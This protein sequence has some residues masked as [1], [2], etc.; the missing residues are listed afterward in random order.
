MSVAAAIEIRAGATL[1]T[2]QQGTGQAG[3]V[4]QKSLLPMAATSESFRSGWQSLLASMG[5]TEKNCLGTQDATDRRT[6]SASTEFSE[7]AVKTSVT[8]LAQAASASS[9]MGQ[10]SGKGSAASSVAATFSTI[11][12]PSEASA[13]RQSSIS[14]QP[15]TTKA[16][17][18]KTATNSKGEPARSAGSTTSASSQNSASIG[19]QEAITTG[20]MPEV[21][22]TAIAS[23]PV[24]APQPA[25]NRAAAVAANAGEQSAQTE[26]QNGLATGSSPAFLGQLPAKLESPGEADETRNAAAPS[27]AKNFETPVEEEQS[28]PASGA[29]GLIATTLRET[30]SSST[31]QSTTPSA[32]ISSGSGALPAAPELVQIPSQTATLNQGIEDAQAAGQSALPTAAWNETPVPALS[33][34]HFVPS[35]SQ[36]Q[37]SA[38]GQSMAQGIAASASNGNLISAADTFQIAQ[39]AAAASSANQ[40]DLASAGKASGAARMARVTASRDAV[41][42]A[43]R[44]TEG[45]TANTAADAPVAMHAVASGTASSSSFRSS[46]NAEGESVSSQAFAALDAEN[47]AEKPAW[48]HTGTRSAEAGFQDPELGWV[49]VRADVSGGGVHA[50]VVTGSADAAQAL[51]GHL[52]G[53]N[54]YLTENNTPVATLTMSSSDSNEAAFNSGQSAGQDSGQGSGQGTAQETNAGSL[55]AISQLRQQSALSTGWQDENAPAATLGGTYISVMA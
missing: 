7:A 48:V 34:S 20:A 37:S 6:T 35:Q 29:R 50:E 51:G 19:T 42:R 36:P 44:L 26:L 16:E 3:S 2:G 28:L 22:S 47:G 15:A 9:R 38:S 30:E 4:A 55:N 11:D 45:Q 41:Q 18:K 10:G 33:S 52:A 13:V 39:P 32:A 27:T 12:L 31:S 5:S 25:I 43:S 54:A 24:A 40:S 53:L 8:V 17:E 21:V 14:A 46:G 23:A 1:A 49:G